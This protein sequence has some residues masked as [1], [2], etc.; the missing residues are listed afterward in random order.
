MSLMQGGMGCVDGKA[1]VKVE[2]VVNPY[3]DP[4]YGEVPEIVFDRKTLFVEK[5]LQRHTASATLVL[6]PRG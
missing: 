4:L 5:H 1:R 6:H 3:V 2:G